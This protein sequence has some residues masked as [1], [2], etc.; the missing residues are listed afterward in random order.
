MPTSRMWVRSSLIGLLLGLVFVGA[1]VPAAAQAFGTVEG[2]V[3]RVGDRAWALGGVTVRVRGT[4]IT[5]TTRANGS[6]T[7]QR[8]PVGTQVVEFRQVGYAAVDLQVTV[9]G[10]QSVT[11]N[12]IMDA[13]P[14]ELGDVVVEGA[15]KAPERIVE[16][17][18]AVAVVE[19]RVLKSSTITAQPGLAIGTMP[20]V[21]AVQSGI[22]DWNINTRGFN[23]SLNRRIL[24]LQDGRDLAIAFL[25]SQEWN[26]LS[27]PLEDI[28]SIDMVRG[29]GSALY[30]ANAFNGVLAITTPTAREVPGSKLTIGGGELGTFQIDARQA[31]VVGQGRWGYRLNLGYNTSE[32]WAK[33]RTSAD[34]LD[35]EREYAP[36]PAE[37]V[38]ATQPEA[39]PL[40]G[41]TL[42][43]VTRE[44]TGTPDKLE[45]VY[46]S[47]RIDYY[48]DNGS[49]VS[50]DG[51]SAQ[52]KNGLFVT[53]IGRVQVQKATRPWA[54]LG[55]SADRFN[56]MAWY[57][58][59]NTKEPQR[60]LS[61]GI[62]LNENSAIYHVEGQTNVGFLDDR[63]RFVIGGSYRN[64]NVNTDST[65][66][67]AVN[68]DRSDNYY[69]VFSQIDYNITS[70]FKA[71]FA[72][73]YDDG[74]LFD[75]QWSP[76]G[77]LVFSPNR[78]HSFR[79]TVS[80]AFQTPNYSEFFLRVPAAAPINLSQLEAGMRASP[81]GPA[82]AGVP[83]G[84]LY[85]SDVAG[86]ASSSTVA[87][88][89]LGNGQ[90]DV[91][92][93][94]AYELGW[95]GDFNRVFVTFGG[96]FNQLE[97]FV[98]DLL[99]GANPAAYPYWIAP[100]AVPD[101][102]KD[103]LV[104]AT[105]AALL[106]QS[107]LAG[108]GLSRVDGVTAVVLS[109]ANAGEVD[110]W[111][112]ELGL[113]WSVTDEWLVKGSYTMFDFDVKTQLVG[114]ILVPNTPKHKGTAEVSYSGRQGL[115]V[116]LQGRFVEG[117]PWAAGVFL[118]DVPSSQT[119]NITAGYRLTNNFR[120]QA[121]VTNI[122][123]QQRFHLYG[124]DVVG[125]RVLAGA[126]AVF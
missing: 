114:D 82:L 63:G 123:D 67:M 53:G 119:I 94:I 111:G 22:N 83:V 109:Y 95:K 34:G 52:V 57:S 35:L 105:R 48:A 103:A 118:G 2:S 107:P 125:R 42:D 44:A 15:S 20:S 13:T 25:G 24:V 88:L 115:D 113:G 12:A 93:V 84:E 80:R 81:L 43:P 62:P 126:T 39:V 19:A 100:A 10:G 59:R 29:P 47:A 121:A 64:Y 51:G 117:Y 17:P 79:A 27:L 75:P 68:D 5:T 23:S 99:P 96:Y 18:A 56:L 91:E 41:Q 45:S 7:L 26:A 92:T 124:G 6:F 98:T 65:L 32:S 60:S 85:G 54:R 30:G 76:K 11:A 104:D 78:N 21:D 58:G 9:A 106:A 61:A 31:G 28:S 89:A 110:E 3:N 122:L 69:S 120:V 46:G 71:V 74:D 112:V 38:G 101:A 97:N 40:F 16:A 37:A 70:Q 4:S 1:A 14:I 116:A 90:L 102:A 55:W 8:V 86:Q 73:R 72:L 108:L 66:M 49:V 50:L 77:G 36:T 33:G 87:A